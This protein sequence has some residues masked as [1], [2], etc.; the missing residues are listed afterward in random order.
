MHRIIENASSVP[1]DELIALFKSSKKHGLTDS[2]IETNK[3]FYG[4]NIF[5]QAEAPALYWLFLGQFFNPLIYILVVAALLIFMFSSETL[6]AFIITGVII[7]NA[8]VGS[9]HE[10]RTESILH[11]LHDLTESFCLV[12]RNGEKKIIKEKDLVCGDILLIK[13]GQRVP[14]DARIV[15]TDHLTV[16]ESTL[17]GE[18]TP[19][20]KIASVIH[21]TSSI[22]EKKNMLFCGTIVL[23]GHATAIICAVGKYTQLGHYTVSALKKQPTIPLHQELEHITFWLLIGIFGL[24]STL[25]IIGLYTNKPPAELFGMLTGLFICVVPEG[26]PVVLT[27][28]LVTGVYRMAKRHALVK[29]LPIVETLGRTQVILT[30]KTGTITHNQ[31]IVTLCYAEKIRWIVEGE[32][33]EEQGLI[34]SLD[35]SA[36][37]LVLKKLGTICVLMNRSTIAHQENK[38]PLIIGDPLEI[39]LAI[40]GKKIGTKIGLLES[41]YD[42]IFDAPFDFKVKYHAAVYA[43]SNGFELFVIG[44]PEMIVQQKQATFFVQYNELLSEGLRVVAVGCKPLLIKKNAFDQLSF[45]EKKNFIHTHVTLGVDILGLCGMQ[46]SIRKEVVHSIERARYA[47]IKV[48]MMTG[49]HSETAQAVALSIGIATSKHQP[50]DGYTINTMS[51]DDLQ[52]VLSY[53]TVYSRLSPYHK[54]RILEAY[55]K[56]KAIVVM[57]G[58][59]INDVPTLL[60]SD[61][62]VVMGSNCTDIARE[63]A[64]LVLL[65]DSFATIID[66]IA[67]GRHI[68]YTLKRVIFYFFSTNLAE[69]FIVIFAFLFDGYYGQNLPL[70]LTAAQILWL[71]LITDGFLDIGISLESE[72]ARLMED[73][74]W[75]EKKQ[76]LFD[77]KIAFKAIL[78]GAFMAICS[79]ILFILYLPYDLAYARS[80]TLITMSLFQW[81]NAWNCRSDHISVTQ[82]SFASNIGFLWIAGG[83]LFLQYTLLY[84]P[85]MQ[86]IFKTVPLHPLDLF[87]AL[88]TAFSII[89]V[90]EIR[91]W[92]ANVD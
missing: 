86:Y 4:A 3:T 83:V 70:P 55:Q 91:K 88:S 82:L 79:L 44:A 6:D 2:T 8:L 32:G 29:N 37:P 68:F 63:A 77:K 33:Y 90:E 1:A 27:L 67:Q 31:M 23:T 5:P 17:T 58:D 51:D 13:P 7:F 34:K 12:I 78:S 71:N 26:L 57:V 53:V 76:T 43:T 9:L 80:M 52:S 14:A 38:A 87:Y 89:I 46:D 85:F 47:G 21:E 62:G 39:A 22:F 60:Q 10:W 41:Q 36:D 74:S 54:V 61:I 49:D 45:S 16:D 35:S 24:C 15:E 84:W 56:N 65:N 28:I 66:A 59:G 30:D 81:F 42:L 64:D 50:L 19:I 48:I 69:V 11:H 72:D 20:I 75:A 73:P 40:F 18:S 25:F 92:Y